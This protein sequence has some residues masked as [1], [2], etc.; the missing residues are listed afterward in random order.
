MKQTFGHTNRQ[1]IIDLMRP[2][3]GYR[4]DAAIGTSYS[5]DFITLTSV[6][7]AFADAEIEEDQKYNIPQ[8]LFAF[9]RLAEKMKLFVNRSCVLLSGVR[10]SSRIC[11][12][13]DNLISEIEIPDGS[14]HPK[15]WLI[16]YV[17][18][19][20]PENV[21]LRPVFRVICGSRN[22]TMGN[23]WELAVQL[24][25]QRANR[26]QSASLGSALADY[27]MHIRG[28]SGSK[29]A[30]LDMAIEQL[31]YIEFSIPEGMDLC[32]FEFQW[33]TVNRLLSRVPS[34]GRKAVVLSPFLGKSFVEMITSNFEE[35]IVISRRR[36]I[37]LKLNEDLITRM[38]PNLFYVNDD[39]S[40]EVDVR[41]NLHAKLYFFDT[42]HDQT[43]MLGSAN[44][45]RNAWQGYNSEA[46]MLFKPGVELSVFLKNFVYDS[47]P[48][49]RLRLHP[50]IER[51]ELADWS[52]R[53]EE[54]ESEK[55]DNLISDAQQTLVKFHFELEFNNDEQTLLLKPCDKE[56]WSLIKPHYDSGL[57]IGAVPISMIEVDN[58]QQW[59]NHRVIDAF[60]DGITYQASIARLTQFICFQI[61]HC[62]T[63]TRRTIVLKSSRDN[64]GDFIEI[65]NK[66]LMRAELTAKQF[67]QFLAAL[68]FDR[69]HP[70]RKAITAILDGTRTGKG[71]RKRS[72]FEVLIEDVMS[73]CT[74]DE[75][76]IAEVTRILEVFEGVDA[77]G[78]PFVDEG[79]RQFW[80]EFKNAFDD[81]ATG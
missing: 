76:R 17:P 6:M 45:S 30:I 47:R 11:A 69:G 53:E 37:E 21:E 28:A 46:M 50:W 72:F 59:V 44:A 80:R 20:M 13:Y 10:E 62:E 43:M 71:N 22:L 23:S 1:S 40:A 74:E 68:L 38:Q 31:P 57:E 35:T 58:D 24:D 3:S 26:R 64:F 63:N 54:T 66:E 34:S 29:S 55:V 52:L 14:F 15:V 16:G 33:P 49:N 70:A 27:F 60:P 42:G 32:Q 56:D 77:D 61:R 4:L 48:E 67:S 18:K 79:F 36:E 41:L 78:I 39:L 9:T 65:R 81:V 51:Y 25:G 12:I 7:L 8:Q 75:S 73:A 2:P 5:V 19:S